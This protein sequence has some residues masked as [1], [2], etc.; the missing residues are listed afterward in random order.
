MSTPFPQVGFSSLAA[1]ADTA[2]CILTLNRMFSTFD[3]LTDKYGVHKV[4]TAFLNDV[5]GACDAVE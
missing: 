4:R 5:L 3:T 1:H 2:D